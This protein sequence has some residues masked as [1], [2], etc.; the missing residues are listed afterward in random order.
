MKADHEM[1][2]E[3]LQEGVQIAVH[4][5]GGLENRA[6]ADGVPRLGGKCGGC[7]ERTS[8]VFKACL[9]GEWL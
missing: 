9:A 2:A 8:E 5:G 6:K 3:D 7:V 4:E 1:R